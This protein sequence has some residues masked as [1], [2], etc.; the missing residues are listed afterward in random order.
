[1]LA[2][3]RWSQ[4]TGDET[5]TV[6]DPATGEP[7]GVVAASSAADVDAAVEAASA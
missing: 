6:T 4:G 2:G 5:F 1:M 3:G 7:L